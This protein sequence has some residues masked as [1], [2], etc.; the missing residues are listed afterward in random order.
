V[1]ALTLSNLQ[2]EMITLR[3]AIRM[4]LAC[5]YRSQPRLGSEQAL[6]F[7]HR[8]ATEFFEA[9]SG[10]RPL[11]AVIS[12]VIDELSEEL[13]ATTSALEAP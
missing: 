3:P 1:D 13:K 6:A 5:C 7:A 8:A 4:G 12:S 10:Y 2:Q 9:R 11:P